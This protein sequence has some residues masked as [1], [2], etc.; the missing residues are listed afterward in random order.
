MGRSS[1]NCRPQLTIPPRMNHFIQTC[2]KDTIY[3]LR[4]AWFKR[5]KL[6]GAKYRTLHGWSRCF[7]LGAWRTKLYLRFQVVFGE[8][9]DQQGVQGRCRAYLAAILWCF[10]VNLSGD[11]GNFLPAAP[12]CVGRRSGQY[13]QKQSVPRQRH[14]G[15]SFPVLYRLYNHCSVEKEA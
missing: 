12:T 11:N 7:L 15:T 6:S 5:K 4:P 8:F 9:L 3:S 2:R 14:A 13:R 10:R 1:G